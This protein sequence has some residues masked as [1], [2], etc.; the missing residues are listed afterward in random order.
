MRASR[1]AL[2]VTLLATP[3]LAAQVR[4]PA[5]GGMTRSLGQPRAWKLHTGVGAGWL[6][7][8]SDGQLVT[9]GRIGI[10]KDLVNPVTGLLG[11][12]FEGYAGARDTDFDRGV[13]AQLVSPFARFGLGVDYNGLDNESNFLIS[14]GH[15]IRRGGA[16]GRGSF[17]RLN[18]LPGRDH[19]FSVGFE[20]PIRRNIPMGRTRPRKDHVPMEIPEVPKLP[21]PTEEEGIQ[22]ALSHVREAAH[23]IHRFTVPFVDHDAFGGDEALLRFAAAMDSLKVHRARTTPLH[24]MGR[25]PAAELRVYHMELDRAFSI[26]SSGRALPASRSTPVGR[27]VSAKAKEIL[28]DEVLLPYNRLLGQ[29]K[30]PDTIRELGT[31]A[32]GIIFTRWLFTESRVPSQR[33]DPVLWVFQELLDIVDANREFAH[34]QWGDSRFVWLP[35][36]YA[37][38]PEQHDSQAELDALIERAI[39]DRTTVEPPRFTD[40]NRVSYLINEQFQVNLARSIHDAEDY[41]VLWIHDFRGVDGITGDPDEVAFRQVVNSYL[42]AMTRRI[43]EY[44]RTGTFPVFMIFL[45]QWF[46]EGRKSRLWMDLLE[47]PFHETDL[48]G[49]NRAWEDTIAIAQQ[50]LRTAIRES[51][52]LQ[53]QAAQFGQDWLR[54]LIRVHVSITNPADPTFWSHQV[55][56]LVGLPDNVMRDH[57]KIAFYDVTEED[58]YRGRAIYTGAGVAEHYTAVSWEDRAIILQGPAALGLKQAARD[59]LL[60]QGIPPEEIPYHLQPRSRAPDYQARVDSVIAHEPT[61]R[62]ME[63]HNQTGFNPKP[64]NT[65]KALLYTLMPA[66]SVIKVP[67]SLWNSSFWGSLLV[68]FALRG[69]R[70][71]VIAPSH[72][73]APSAGFAQLARAKEL[74]SRL[75]T[76][77]TILQEE[78]AAEG[79]LLKVGIFHPDFAVTD[80]AQKVQ[81]VRTALANYSWLRDL[82]D[83]HPDVSSALQEAQQWLDTLDLTSLPEEFESF[84]QPKL[85]IKAN[86]FASAEAWAGLMSRPEWVGVLRQFLE[87]R[88]DQIQRR[89]Q[90]ISSDAAEVSLID[91]GRPMVQAWLA[92]LSPKELER[93]V[94]FLAVGSHNQ[95]NR[96]IIMDGEVAVIL[97][98]WAMIGGFIDMVSIAGQCV[99]VESVQELERHQA[100]Y[101]EWQRRIGRWIKLA[102]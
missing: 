10:Y 31:R 84:E 93:I 16:F 8:E 26:A 97:S 4:A 72:E 28:L 55:I 15:P 98:S 71:L 77:N 9:E 19:S 69:G 23:W 83:F 12:H 2:L 60:N 101:S 41:H 36:Q 54:D 22:D 45:D 95:N 35:L 6:F 62:A 99:W 3:T 94:F 90:L 79:G 85:H 33:R 92:E 86:L 61:A 21:P 78:I 32:L 88:V 39:D 76:A 66:G 25:T 1:L 68:G 56:P 40:G 47:D 27:E 29:R 67:D 73:N 24:P 49:A 59:L 89:Q 96:S 65:L 50:E 5:D 70:A 30:D 53:H 63:I 75:V 52:L 100:E 20:F 91:V 14:I 38:V 34:R 102:L 7:R 11:L 82:Y 13:R 17:L 57:R 81:S 43:R 46:Y 58:P 44:D 37:L 80:I 64:I 51:S 42:A 48:P 87:S 18:Y 74:M